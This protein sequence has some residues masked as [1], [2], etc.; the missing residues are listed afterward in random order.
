[1]RAPIPVPFHISPHPVQSPFV[2]RSNE[3]E[4]GHRRFC[5]LG[6]IVPPRPPLDNDNV[7]PFDGIVEPKLV[8]EMCGAVPATKDTDSLLDSLALKFTE[9]HCIPNGSRSIGAGFRRL[10]RMLP[11]LPK[12]PSDFIKIVIVRQRY[13]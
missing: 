7:V 10:Y 1:M 4:L 6:L 5:P 2:C 12:T 13:P 9:G 3:F 8:F 11:F